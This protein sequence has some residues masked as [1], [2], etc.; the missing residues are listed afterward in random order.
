MGAV[1]LDIIVVAVCGVWVAV[2]VVVFVDT[3]R[4]EV[5]IEV[6]EFVDDGVITIGVYVVTILWG[7]MVDIRVDELLLLSHI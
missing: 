6:G 4:L 3:I 7:A 1:R 5:A 2:I